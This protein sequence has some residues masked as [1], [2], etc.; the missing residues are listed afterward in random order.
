MVYYAIVYSHLQYCNVTWGNA[1]TTTLLPLQCTM[2]KIMRIISFA[3]F[4]SSNIALLY[5][6]YGLLQLSQIHELEL[7]KLMFKH[8]NKMLPERF[9]RHFSSISSV[10]THST[11]SRT[12]DNFFIPRVRTSLGQKTIKVTGPKLWNSVPD[13]K[14]A[15][16]DWQF[17]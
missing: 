11:R 10:H 3:P 6:N 9:N 2:N 5:K 1:S 12:R 8:K 13:Y 7:G 14:S 15:Q 16:F 17:F 4:N